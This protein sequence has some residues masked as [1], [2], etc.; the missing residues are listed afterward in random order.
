MKPS[1]WIYAGGVAIMLA[2]L[3]LFWPALILVPI[4]GYGAHHQREAEKQ[5]AI[6]A[7]YAHTRRP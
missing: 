4:I 5:Q 7:R 3:F 1:Y 6:R 2:G